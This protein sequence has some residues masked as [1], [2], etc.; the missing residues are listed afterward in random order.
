MTAPRFGEDR[1][2]TAVSYTKTPF[3]NEWAV[4]VVERRDGVFRRTSFSGPSAETSAL[5]YARLQGALPRRGLGQ[6]LYRCELRRFGLEALWCSR[7]PM[8]RLAGTL[9]T[10]R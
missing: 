6:L 3:L 5:K 8:G 4:F 10:G 1:P 9:P 7:A 2:R